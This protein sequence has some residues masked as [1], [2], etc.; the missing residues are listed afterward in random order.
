MEIFG[1]YSDNRMSDVTLGRT[2]T[3]QMLSRGGMYICA[4]DPMLRIVS[5]LVL[6]VIR[7][8]PG[9]LFRHVAGGIKGN[10]EDHVVRGGVSSKVRMGHVD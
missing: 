6:S 4:D 7:K 5:V 8:D 3:F 1:V 10:R 2:T 9:T